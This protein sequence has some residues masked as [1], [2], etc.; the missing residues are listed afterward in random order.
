MAS[1][2]QAE[3]QA[4]AEASR[5]IARKGLVAGS[6]GNVSM[7]LAGDRQLLAITP[8]GKSYQDLAA[9]DIQVITFEG[10]PVEGDR[11]PSVE[12]L[13][14][15][16]AYHARPSIRAVVHTHSIYASALAV[17]HLEL[18]PIIDEMVIAIGGAV[19]V[20]SYATPGSE[21]LAERVGSALKARN[22]ALIAN[23]GV[24]GVGADLRE[25]LAICEMVERGSQIYVIARMLG[26]DNALPNAVVA[27]EAQL[28]RM[29]H[30]AP[31]PEQPEGESNQ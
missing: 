7:R 31:K 24:V 8:S 18:P 16:A 25:A 11:L 5:E 21:E 19:P 23:H 2:W 10:D 27:T 28:F 20:T 17:A 9:D 15:A 26:R 4:V 13:M 29:M 14:H 30:L 3:K 6:A 1:Q 22:A 12:T